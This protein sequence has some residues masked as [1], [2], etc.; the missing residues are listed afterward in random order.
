VTRVLPTLEELAAGGEVAVIGLGR[1]GVAAARLIRSVG[2]A[3]YVSDRAESAA[4]T[5]NAELLRAA[6][7]AVDVGSHNLARIA[8]ASRVVV[9]PGVPPDAPPL[10]AAR[11]AGV[12]VMSEVE[13]ALRAMPEVPYVAVT[14]TNGKTTVTAMIAHLFRAMGLEAAAG[15]NIGTPLA[16]LA[17]G[18]TRPAWLALELSSFQLHDTPS[19][20][21]RVAVLTNLAPDHLDRYESLEAYYADKDLLFRNA[22]E[23]SIRVVNG[24]DAEVLRRTA[25][26]PGIARRFSVASAHA[27]AAYDARAAMLLL[28]GSPLLERALLPLLGPHNVANALAAVLAVWQALPTE[29]TATGRAKLAVGLQ[30]FR[31]IAHR[32]EALGERDGVLYVNDSKATNVG[33]ARVAIEA[34]DRPTVLLLGGRHKGEPYT[35]L[36]PAMQ[37]RVH[38]VI[39]FGEAEERIVADLAGQGN[40][41]VERGGSSFAQVM[42]RARAAAGAGDAIL[43]APACSSFDMFTNYEERGAQ[44]RALALGS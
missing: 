37:G 43:L 13:L 34:M 44:F 28:E 42:A 14:G 20:A 5:A 15:G 33:A 39:A 12:P 16:E 23:T 6:G 36:L 41:A 26:V 27:D 8:A 25:H 19:V 29:H 38:T 7:I 3:V 31:A 32:L 22:G 40:V 21:P 30:S 24:D 10:A 11:A 9:S 17:L 18:A 1:S 4:V 35:G 2:G